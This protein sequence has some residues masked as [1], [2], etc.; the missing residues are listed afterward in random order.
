MV[1]E[2]NTLLDAIEKIGE[3]YLYYNSDTPAKDMYLIAAKV[4]KEVTGSNLRESI[5]NERA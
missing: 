3:T 5:E 4:Y 2:R 1:T